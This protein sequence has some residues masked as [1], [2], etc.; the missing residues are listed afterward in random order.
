[1]LKRNERREG[2]VGSNPSAVVTRPHVTLETVGRFYEERV[3]KVV[4][5][6]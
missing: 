5:G 6:G 4:H 1:M 2:D 3:A